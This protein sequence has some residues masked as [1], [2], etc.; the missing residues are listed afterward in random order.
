ME[1]HKV[2]NL[3]D[4]RSTKLPTP[5]EDKLNT[6]GGKQF[7]V[8]KLLASAIVPIQLLVNPAG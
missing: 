6:L 8:D 4:L 1:E 5:I 3:S 2:A 7:V